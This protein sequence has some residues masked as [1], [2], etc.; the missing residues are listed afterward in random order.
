MKKWR[1]GTL[2]MGL[3]LVLLGIILFLSQWSGL[4]AFDAFISWWPMIFVLLGLEIIVYLALG[5]KEDSRI[6]YDILSL[7][8]VGVLCIGCLG[9]TMLTSVGVMGELRSIMGTV[10]ETKDLPAVKEVLA[11]GVKKVVVQSADQ[12]V[13]V[14][15]STERTVNVFGTYHSRGKQGEQ[16]QPV[17]KE[18]FVALNTIGDTLYV[19]LK[20][21]PEKR[22]IDSFYPWVQATVV[23][24]QDVQ[25]E[26]RGA[27][28][29]VVP[30]P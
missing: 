3:S 5:R 29:Q 6:S 24:P 19:Q 27:N 4:Q 15:K 16:T 25:V 18:Q 13:K 26:V 1:V 12:T 9:F 22:G 28:N 23:L 11:E 7:F 14:D 8:F 20:R 17:A 21:L 2:S 10:E 30:N